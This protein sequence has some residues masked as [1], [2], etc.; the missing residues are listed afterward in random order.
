[1]RSSE[2][3][4]SEQARH[5]LG[6]Q[7]ALVIGLAREGVDLARFLTRHGAS[8]TVTDQKP[9]DQL[10]EAIGELGDAPVSYRLGGHSLTDLDRIDVVYA[11]PGVPP[12]HLLLQAARERGIRLSSLVELF[13]ALCPAP[14]VG[15]TGSAGKSTTTSLVGQIFERA[16]RHVFVGG[17]I[18]RPLLGKLE[19]LTPASW[20]VMELSSFQLEPL[21]VSPHVALVTNVTPNHLDRH[22]SMEAYWAAKGQILAHQAPTDW[23]VLNADDAWSLRYRPRGR[24]L[25]FSLEGVV[26]GAYL[27]GEH[28]MLLGEPLLDTIDVPLRGRHNIANVLAAAATAHAAGIE[29]DAMRAAIRAFQGVAHRLETVAERDG[30]KF[31]NDSIAT[32]PERSIAALQAYHEPLV[33]IAGGRDKHLPMEHWAALIARRVKHVV[34][35]GEMSDL[36]AQAIRAADPGYTAISRATSMDEAVR[37]AATAA[38][39]GDV[40][41]L[42]PGGTSYDMYRDFEERG[43]DFARAVAELQL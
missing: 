43:R 11:S 39:G 29:R 25:R 10:S 13:F 1:M 28:L 23:S 36:V 30:V 40:V 20:V 12:E 14:I 24:V 22:P 4:V 35:L 6:G 18:G 5:L 7:R 21:Q 37:Q 34:L 31:V 38:R 41:L 27:A 2:V 26:E 15:I 32:A 33:L 19:E 17:N 9:A 3:T 8:V 16:E 42:S